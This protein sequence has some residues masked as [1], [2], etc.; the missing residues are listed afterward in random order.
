M[1]LNGH[2]VYLNGEGGIPIAATLARHPAGVMGIRRATLEEQAGLNVTHGLYRQ[3]T[4]QDIHWK[5]RSDGSVGCTPGWLPYV[6]GDGK[7]VMFTRETL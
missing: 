1:P 6:S 3:V 5:I 4:V 2:F 7:L